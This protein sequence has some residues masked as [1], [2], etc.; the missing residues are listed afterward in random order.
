MCSV[1]RWMGV[2]LVVAAVALVPAFAEVGVAIDSGSSL[3]V[4][5]IIAGITDDPEP[6]GNAW[7]RYSAE[8]GG[9]EVLNSEGFANGDGPPSLKVTAGVP[10]VAWA[11]NSTDGYDVVFSRFAGGVWT[12]PQHVASSADDELDPFL[13]V[14]P[15]DGSVHLV[16]W[17]DDDTPRVMYRQASSDLSSWGAPVQVSHPNEVAVR[18]SGAFHDGVL[19]VVYEVHDFG[20]GTTPRQ[21]VMATQQGAIFTSELLA[22]T[23][24]AG[25]NEP[26]AHCASG[27]LWVD[28]VDAD[29]EMA[30]TRQLPT[31]SWLSVAI[32]F[33]QTTEE[34]DYFVRGTIRE[35]A[36]GLD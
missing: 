20:F 25:D 23:Q 3:P 35:Q 15:I 13:I 17:I 1:R 21:I 18:P 19:K 16:Y 22:T 6:I 8:G 2:V 5:Y 33:F 11:K 10:V 28:W 9:R 31:G 4:S 30:W 12:V 24:F 26:T 7:I 34:L 36:L 29:G 32:E 27:T 14:S